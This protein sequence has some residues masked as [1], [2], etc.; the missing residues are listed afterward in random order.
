MDTQPYIQEIESAYRDLY[1]AHQELQAASAQYSSLVRAEYKQHIADLTQD[2]PGLQRALADW[3][4]PVW[5]DF[6]PSA[7]TPLCSAARV[8]RLVYSED[9]LQNDLPALLP[10]IG[11]KHVVVQGN[12]LEGA[13]RLV[14]QIVFR[15]VLT[16][17]PK[18]VRVNLVDPDGGGNNLAWLLRLPA[19]L[20]NDKVATRRQDM[21]QLIEELAAHVEQVIQTRLLNTYPNLEAYNEQHP[22]IAV[23]YQIIALSAQTL[24]L[25]RESWQRFEFVA[26]KGI[27]AGV[28][29]VGLA[30]NGDAKQAPLADALRVTVTNGRAQWSDGAQE[31]ILA[32]LDAPPTAAQINAWG[33]TL[34]D[35]LDQQK[36]S[37]PFARMAIPPARRWQTSAIEELRVPIGIDASG[38]TQEFSLGKSNFHALVGG[39]TGYGKS[40]LL[41]VIITQ[42]ALAYAPEELGFYLVDLKEGVAFQDYLRLPHVRVISLENEREFGLNLLRNVQDEIAQRGELFRAEQRGIEDYASYRSTTGKRLARL[43][44]ILDEFQVLFEQDD[45]IAR[46]AGKILEDLA[47]RGR[48]FGIHVILASQAPRASAV[49]FDR[50]LGQVGLRIAFRCDERVSQALLGEG[51]DAATELE[52]PGEAIYNAAMGSRARNTRI[53]VALLDIA[54][55]Q[56]HLQENIVRGGDAYPAPITFE[57]KAAAR[58]QDNPDYQRALAQPREARARRSVQV[59]LGEPIEI[60]APTAATLQRYA[61]SNLLI[62]GGD[63][64][65]AYGL[66]SAVLLSL[67][68]QT[69]PPHSRFIVADFA[70]PESDVEEVF[71]RVAAQAGVGIER[72]NSRVAA[73][74]LGELVTTVSERLNGQAPVEPTTYFLITGIQRWREL[75]SADSFKPSEGATQLTRLLEEGAEAGVHVVL[76]SDSLANYERVLKRG[77][78]SAF[79]QR[80]GLRLT[81]S[82]SVALFGTKAAAEFEA[83]RALY[84]NEEDPVGQ[85]EKFKPYP[86][87]M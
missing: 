44:L 21:E 81:E 23:P 41:D 35:A 82:D 30:F 12:D 75:R 40:K 4:D 16:A 83:N 15:I 62:A 78:L 53:R 42:M 74:L 26:D 28:Y 85:V 43:V 39:M 79:D 32:E 66:F 19:S 17:P 37:V 73:T 70:R 3:E 20:R 65:Q 61:G 18:S 86:L 60:K 76:W 64:L 9:S 29:I 80:V 68:A 46:E 33:K 50:I 11:N 8:G 6:V 25:S 56:Q 52:Q 71:A 14:Q 51:N 63:E 58:L 69:A 34:A 49:N 1:V 84:R 48:A 22:E 36:T 2:A 24:D 47:R 87:A 54:E 7:D 55:R 27:A 10:L 31:T 13:R 38:A 57:S 72:V 45:A 5:A 59:W 77:T 67:V